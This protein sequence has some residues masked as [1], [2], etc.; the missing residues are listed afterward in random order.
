MPFLI[1]AQRDAPEGGKQGHARQSADLLHHKQRARVELSARAMVQY[2]PL[3]RSSLQKLLLSPSMLAAHE[4][5]R[6]EQAG[7]QQNQAGW[8]RGDCGR[9]RIGHKDLGLA[10]VGLSAIDGNERNVIPEVAGGLGGSIV[11][12]VLGQTL[13]SCVESA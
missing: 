9:D 4:G 1:L 10:P 8:F 13:G 7:P 5:D 2:I 3:N 11:D 6:A 12:G